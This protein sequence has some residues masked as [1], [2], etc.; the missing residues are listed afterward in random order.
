LFAIGL[1]DYEL[2]ELITRKIIGVPTIE[3][4]LRSALTEYPPETGLDL[5]IVP[6]LAG[7]AEKEQKRCQSRN[8][9]RNEWHFLK[10]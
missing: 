2:R 9:V 8:G 5:V 6:R 10:F 4:Q 1:E 7:E 3:D